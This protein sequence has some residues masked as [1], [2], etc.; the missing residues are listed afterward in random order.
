MKKVENDDK[1]YTVTIEDKKKQKRELT[2]V[3]K[4]LPFEDKKIALQRA[5]KFMKENPKGIPKKTDC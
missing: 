1:K 2:E 4:G 5:K 3:T